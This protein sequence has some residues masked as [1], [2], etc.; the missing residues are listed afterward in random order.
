[1]TGELRLG[2]VRRLIAPLITR[3]FRRSI[4]TN[5]A[6]LKQ[7]LGASM[8]PALADRSLSRRKSRSATGSWSAQPCPV[9][10]VAATIRAAASTSARLVGTYDG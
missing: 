7:D 6:R 9:K 10:E 8:Q 1:V 3:S 2:G 4:Q 5:F